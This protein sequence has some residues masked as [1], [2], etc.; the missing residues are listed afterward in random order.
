M[1][2][3]PQNGQGFSK[4]SVI[5]SFEIFGALPQPAK[6]VIVPNA[7]RRKLHFLFVRQVYSGL[8]RPLPA[9]AVDH[10]HHVQQHT[11][12]PFALPQLGFAN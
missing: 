4:S 6:L 1:S 8:V 11:S 5:G 2:L 10:C 7:L 12:M 9:V 3:A